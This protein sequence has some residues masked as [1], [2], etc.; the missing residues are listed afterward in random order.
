MHST[1]KH[2]AI[3][4]GDVHNCTSTTPYVYMALWRCS[5][6]VARSPQDKGHLRLE[7]GPVSVPKNRSTLARLW[8]HCVQ[9]FDLGNRF[10][11]GYVCVILTYDTLFLSFEISIYLFVP[12]SGLML[13]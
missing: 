1:A 13:V 3:E 11:L 5:M 7:C 10:F 8:V 2:L 9:G 6:H 4:F 12:A